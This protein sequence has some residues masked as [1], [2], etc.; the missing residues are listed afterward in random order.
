M[1]TNS[2]LSSD[3]DQLKIL[4]KSS[5]NYLTNLFN[6]LRKQLR[7]IDLKSKVNQFEK[8]HL[9]N[10]LTVEIQNELKKQIELIESK[11]KELKESDEQTDVDETDLDEQD[12]IEEEDEEDDDDEDELDD[13]EKDINELIQS[14]LSKAQK[15]LFNN[16]SLI[17]LNS[18]NCKET[19][20]LNGYD[21]R[22]IIV[23][24][25]YLSNKGIENLKKK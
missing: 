8:E 18:Q 11:L 10:Q 24:D 15:C 20:L 17:Y 23:S 13:D 4:L 22:L 6:D 14:S 21:E 3:L 9:S 1:A 7:S 25:E 12:D 19:S 16:K 5:S 2:K